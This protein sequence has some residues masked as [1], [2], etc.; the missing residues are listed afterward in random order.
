MH[1]INGQ[2]EWFLVCSGVQIIPIKSSGCVSLPVSQQLNIKAVKSH[3]LVSG[4][5]LH[6]K[7]ARAWIEGNHSLQRS[8][9][10]RQSLV[11]VGD[12]Q[13]EMDENEW[14][15]ALCGDATILFLL[16]F[17]T[18]SLYSAASYQKGLARRPEA[19]LIHNNGRVNR[20]S[21]SKHSCPRSALPYSPSL[22]IKTP[23]TASVLSTAV[24]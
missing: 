11:L 12:K 20:V 21:S 16:L 15:S 4:T 24:L 9:M 17:C 14:G 6:L 13:A 7:P 23:K 3:P 19:W 5:K 18:R 10:A 2:S 1:H 8:I 22:Y